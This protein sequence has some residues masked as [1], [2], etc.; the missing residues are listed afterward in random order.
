MAIKISSLVAEKDQLSLGRIMCWIAFGLLVWMWATAMKVPPTLVESFWGLLIYNGGK[1]VTGPLLAFLQFRQTGKLPDLSQMEKTE[2]KPAR[3]K[4]VVT[5]TVI[6][7]AF[8]DE[9]DTRIQEPA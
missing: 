7:E 6:A 5:E 4:A 9:E 8:P 2:E 3:E 1:H